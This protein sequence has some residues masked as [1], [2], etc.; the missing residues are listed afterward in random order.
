MFKKKKKLIPIRVYSDHFEGFSILGQN[1]FISNERGVYFCHSI[2]NKMTEIQSSRET[3]LIMFLDY[4]H[5]V[6]DLTYHSVF[7]Y[8]SDMVC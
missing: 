2:N 4:K 8:D 6:I 5:L 7:H 1:R 3:L